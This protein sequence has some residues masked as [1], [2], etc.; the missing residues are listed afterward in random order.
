MPIS[1]L[2]YLL[3]KEELSNAKGIVL[4]FLI[5]QTKRYAAGEFLKF[6]QGIE[7][8]SESKKT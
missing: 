1:V 2:A 5:A 7:N 3:D 4:S 6:C 8:P